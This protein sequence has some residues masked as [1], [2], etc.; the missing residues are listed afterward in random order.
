MTAYER[1]ID[2]VSLD[3]VPHFDGIDGSLDPSVAPRVTPELEPTSIE[4]TMY[5][6]VRASGCET[7]DCVS[8]IEVVHELGRP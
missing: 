7:P 2:L 5:Y 3:A 4:L 8:L 1:S 6:Q